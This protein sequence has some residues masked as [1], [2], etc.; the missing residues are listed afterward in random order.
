MK[1]VQ[2]TPKLLTRFWA[3]V[4]KNGPEVSGL[5]VCWV[6]TAS[7]LAKGYGQF[8]LTRSISE[9]AHRV[10]F[11]IE[12]GRGP[13]GGVVRHGCD[14][15]SCVRPEHLEEGTLLDNNRDAAHRGRTARG[16]KNGAAKLNEARVKEIRQRFVGG[17][18]Q[19]KLA[20]EFGVTQPLVSDIVNRKM[21]KH[22]A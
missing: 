15:P 13:I 20:R 1:H 10:A 12:H 9:L 3:K 16:E 17:E 19:G 6:W 8:G 2:V 11:V 21:W 14:N 4:N 7:K 5:G 18:S 22:V